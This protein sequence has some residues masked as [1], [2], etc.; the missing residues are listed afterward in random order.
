MLFSK[1]RAPISWVLDS[2]IISSY[3]LSW[4]SC[5]CVFFGYYTDSSSSL[6]HKKIGHVLLYWS[7]LGTECLL[8]TKYYSSGPQSVFV[9]NYNQWI[10]NLFSMLSPLFLR[11]LPSPI[12][13]GFITANTWILMMS[14]RILYL[15]YKMNRSLPRICVSLHQR[16]HS[17]SSFREYHLWNLGWGGGSYY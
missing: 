9:F 11:S 13:A 17:A 8:R 6:S 14:K 16:M 5:N 2:Q 4:G 3:R 7:L 1:N 15:L 10:L 12:S